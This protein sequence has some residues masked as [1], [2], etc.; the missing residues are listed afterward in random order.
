M[1]SR[2]HAVAD[3][4]VVSVI[5]VADL[6]LGPKVVLQ[7]VRQMKPSPLPVEVRLV[8]SP[9]EVL[10]TV[11]RIVVFRTPL[12]ELPSQPRGDAK[13]LDIH[14]TGPAG[15]P[16]PQRVLDA[17][18]EH[19][20]HQSRPLRIHTH[21][22]IMRA[23]ATAVHR[24]PAAR[25]PRRIG[26]SGGDV[27]ERA[28]AAASSPN[29]GRIEYEYSPGTARKL[30]TWGPVFRDAGRMKRELVRQAAVRTV[31]L[32]PLTGAGLVAAYWDARDASGG[33]NI[34]LGLLVL[35]GQSLVALCWAAADA[36][37]REVGEAL[38]VWVAASMLGS[39]GGLLISRLL[40]ARELGW[41]WTVFVSDLLLVVPTTATL[42]IVAAG[43]G[44][45]VG[46][47]TRGSS[48]VR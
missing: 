39:L 44:V 18:L 40:E 8:A 34:G 5:E 30:M 41:S 23:W 6:G 16:V 11:R 42:T 15:R 10:R 28:S 19:H 25:S 31:A 3:G 46:V 47:V 1:R 12:T 37:R 24:R 48:S 14:Q 27:G 17:P 4:T 45:L 9:L 38:G 20:Q 36:R 35:F 22:P 29:S 21:R 2:S 13:R 43:I 33:V 32:V 26:Y 7:R